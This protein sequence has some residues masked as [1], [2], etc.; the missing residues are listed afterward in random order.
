MAFGI[1][2]KFGFSGILMLAAIAV[3]AVSVAL[4]G[5]PAMSQWSGV[6]EAYVTYIAAGIC[7]VVAVAASRMV[8]KMTAA[9][10]S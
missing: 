2:Q 1:R 9:G 10:E 7:F 6:S 3:L 8:R 4:V 5:I